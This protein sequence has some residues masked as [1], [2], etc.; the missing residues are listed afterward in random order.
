MAEVIEELGYD[1]ERLGEADDV[2]VEITS[3]GDSVYD[4]ELYGNDR[5]FA[6][7]LPRDICQALWDYQQDCDIDGFL[8]LAREFFFE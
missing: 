4:A 7:T 3:N 5:T 2:I 6:D 8:P 1:W